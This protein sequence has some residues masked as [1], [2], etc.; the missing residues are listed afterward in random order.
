[1]IIK[2]NECDLTSLNCLASN[3]N[4]IY[5]IDYL[6]EKF[7]YIYGYKVNNS[8]VAYL[9]Y[10][11]YFERAEINYLFVKKEFRNKKIATKLLEYMFKNISNVS[12][13]TLEVREKNVAAINL[14][15]KNGFNKCSIRKNYYGNEDALL[16]IRKC[17]E[18]NE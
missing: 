9:D 11:V 13:I 5:K 12:S 10:S 18:K 4:I 6:K 3:F 1:M 17:G 15:L 8:I 7:N 14:Y 16:L 2:I